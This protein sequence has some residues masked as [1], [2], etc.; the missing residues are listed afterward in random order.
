MATTS[1]SHAAGHAPENP[2]RRDF[3]YIATGA[4]AAVG[5][6]AVAWPF[7]SQMKPDAATLAAG[8]PVDFDLAPGEFCQVTGVG[9]VIQAPLDMRRQ[10]VWRTGLDL[11]GYTAQNEQF[12]V[13]WFPH[14]RLD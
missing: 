2:E 3:L 14:A 4:A 5:A 13:A 9:A 8:A 1:A 11:V 7:I 12:R 10:P 6:A